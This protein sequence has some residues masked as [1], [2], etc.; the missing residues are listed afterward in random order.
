MLL[1]VN[2]FTLIYCKHK[3]LEYCSEN[4]M[5]VFSFVSCFINNGVM[6]VSLNKTDLVFLI[7][8]WV[9]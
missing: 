3:N 1:T 6:G 2:A 8:R 9:V 4:S 5:K 7:F